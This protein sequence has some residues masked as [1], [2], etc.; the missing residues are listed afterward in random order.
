MD[1]TII[2]EHNPTE[3]ELINASKNMMFNMPFFKFLPIMIVFILLVNLLPSILGIELT[4]KQ[5]KETFFESFMP[6]LA[7]PLIWGILIYSSIRS[8]KKRIRTNPKS[9][10]K[11][12]LTFTSTSIVQKGETFEI[13]YFWK[14]IFRIKETN[15]WFLIY[16]N[17]LNALPLIKSDLKDNQ[18]NELLTLFNSLP[19]KKS[20]K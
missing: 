6:F 3:E 2:I 15:K 20:L 14:D 10:E 16:T 8:I 19:I 18:Y 4:H 1:K 5:E 17:K 11:Q 12:K 13:E 7:L 9:L